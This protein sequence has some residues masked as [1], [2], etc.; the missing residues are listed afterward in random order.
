M[1]DESNE[2]SCP[3]SAS[4][5]QPSEGLVMPE[6]LELPVE[7][8]CISK[9]CNRNT[10]ADDI[11]GLA[12]SIEQVGLLLPLCV[13][14][15]AAAK[16]NLIDG[17][18][19]LLAMRQLGKLTVRCQILDVPEEQAACMSWMANAERLDRTP[20]EQ[21]R[22]I[23]D[24]VDTFGKTEAQVGEMLK[25][26]QS[27][28]HERASLLNLPE[29]V[30]KGVG[31]SL[32]YS[33]AVLLARLMEGELHGREAMMRK[34]LAKILTGRVSTTE[35]RSVVKYI[36][37]GRLPGLPPTLQE[38]LLTHPLM[39]F[40]MLAFY[41]QP[42]SLLAG[43]GKNG[44]R[45]RAA[46][47]QVPMPERQAFIEQCVKRGKSFDDA[48][49]LWLK[50][51]EK[52]VHE[53]VDEA[54]AHTPSTADRLFETLSDLMEGVETLNYQKSA[55]QGLDSQQ[56]EQMKT[57][58]DRIANGMGDVVDWIDALDRETKLAPGGAHEKELA[59]DPVD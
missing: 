40:S 2:M 34:L 25:M 12:K 59:H 4:L 23:K 6:V 41:E 3:T 22:F 50:R 27:T 43:E 48:R 10:E 52:L 20:M 39:T 31:T 58:V 19:R 44:E 57:Q 42:A 46:A 7:S 47:D 33:Q 32:S 36:T 15:D 28:V 24:I 56:M 1:S 30:Q 8:I 14:M 53:Q 21:A 51:I 38:L 35:L 49:K 37:D 54:P 17:S 55:I 11:S 45:L 26:A 18:R 5:A 13:R 16:Y 9:F 29:D